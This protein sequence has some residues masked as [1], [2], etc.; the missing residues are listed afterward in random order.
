[1]SEKYQNFT[2]LWLSAESSSQNEN[3][4]NNGKNFPEYRN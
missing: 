1:M 2:E 4:I 3:F